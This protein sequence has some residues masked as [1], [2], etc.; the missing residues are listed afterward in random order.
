MFADSFD[1]RSINDYSSSD[2]DSVI[3]LFIS[4]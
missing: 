3:S 2:V 1:T 4:C